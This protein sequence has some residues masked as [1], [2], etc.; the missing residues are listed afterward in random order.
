[1]LNQTGLKG[2]FFI[3]ESAYEIRAVRGTPIARLCGAGLQKIRLRRRKS[4]TYTRHSSASGPEDKASASADSDLHQFAL[5]IEF[6]LR[7]PK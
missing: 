4:E 2:R 3:L 6:L 1:M 5:G 7:N